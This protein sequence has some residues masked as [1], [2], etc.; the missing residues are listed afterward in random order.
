[1][2]TPEQMSFATIYETT[3]MKHVFVSCQLFA[4]LRELARLNMDT[5]RFVFSGAALRWESVLLAQ[6]P[7][8]FVRHQ[9]EAMPWLAMQ[10]AGYTRGWMDIASEAN[11]NLVRT[12]SD[13][14]D[15]PVRRVT[16]GCV[17]QRN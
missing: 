3:A 4:G 7:E 13:R 8:Q 10:V 16:E 9:A 11:A 15:E 1:V 6:T 2:S 14:G 5:C 17:L 12:T